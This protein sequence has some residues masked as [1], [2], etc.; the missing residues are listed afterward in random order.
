MPVCP[1]IPE[2]RDVSSLSDSL[3]WSSEDQTVIVGQTV[4]FEFSILKSFKMKAYINGCGT[5]ICQTNINGTHLLCTFN[6]VQLSDN[7][8]QIKVFV[9]DKYGG[10]VCFQPVYLYVEGP[11]PPVKIY[12]TIITCDSVMINI[13]DIPINTDLSYIVYGR[14]GLV[15]NASSNSTIINIPGDVFDNRTG[16]YDVSVYLI[17]LDRVLLLIQV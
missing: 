16:V 10:A 14:E 7:H 13:S 2:G 15:Y 11:P 17:L 3:D 9:F 4:S 8:T 12:D 6:N 5:D 1:L